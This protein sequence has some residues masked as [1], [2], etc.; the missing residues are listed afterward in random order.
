MRYDP[1]YIQEVGAVALMQ[2]G[3]IDYEQIADLVG[4][5]PEQVE[6]IDLSTN[7][8]IRA[9]TIAGVPLGEFAELRRAIRC[10]RC[11]ALVNKAP[12]LACQLHRRRQPSGKPF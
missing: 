4:I 3:Y 7:P 12:C 9:W 6:A 1:V 2:M 5:L 11:G 10:R 8:R